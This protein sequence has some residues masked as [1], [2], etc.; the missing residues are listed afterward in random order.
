MFLQSP[1][2]SVATHLESYHLQRYYTSQLDNLYDNI[3]VNQLEVTRH[4]DYAYDK[5]WG[6]GRTNI[7]KAMNCKCKFFLRRMI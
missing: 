3:E 7:L 6:D 1:T 5:M 2:Q 4:R